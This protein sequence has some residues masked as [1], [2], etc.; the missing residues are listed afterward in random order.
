MKTRACIRMSIL[1]TILLVMVAQS[2]SADIPSQYI[3]KVDQSLIAVYCSLNPPETEP[4]ANEALASAVSLVNLQSQFAVFNIGGMWWMSGF[5]V[6][7]ATTEEL[8]GNGVIVRTRIDSLMTVAIPIDSIPSVVAIPGVRFIEIAKVVGK[9]LNQSSQKIT[10]RQTQ[11]WFGLD[12]RN[13]VMGIVDSGIDFDGLDFKNDDGTTRILYLWDQ[14]STIGPP[15]SGYN[16]GREWT[17]SQINSGL[18]SHVDDNGH[19]TEVVPGLVEI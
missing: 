18:C 11:D 14:N 16:Y 19:G 4:S 17:A 7:S 10:A 8:V 13:V 12:G 15:P 5:L 1:P 9:Q 3:H 6:G 2:L